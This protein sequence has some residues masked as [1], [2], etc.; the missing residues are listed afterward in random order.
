[1]INHLCYMLSK[2]GQRTAKSE[3]KSIP[4]ENKRN[5]RLGTENKQYGQ[6]YSGTVQTL[7]T[8]VCRLP[9]KSN[10]TYIEI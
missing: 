8:D 6:S 3:N 10:T 1:M 5:I 4:K 2:E 7:A 9:T